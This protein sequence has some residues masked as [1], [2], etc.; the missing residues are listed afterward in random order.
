MN[1]TNLCDTYFAMLEIPSLREMDIVACQIRHR[2]ASF[3]PAI[4]ARSAGIDFSSDDD[5]Y[6]HWLD[7]GRQLGLEWA[8]GKDTLLKIILKAKNEA[9]LIDAWVE[10]HAAIVGYENLIILDCGSDDPQYLR[11]LWAIGQRVL[12]LPFRYYYDHL[13]WIFANP[14][15]FKLISQNCR[16]LTIL[17]ADEFL[18]GRSGQFFSGSLVKPVLR[19][20][21]LPFHCGTW[22]EARGGAALEGMKTVPDWAFDVSIGALVLGTHAGKAVARSD[23]IFEINYLSHNFHVASAAKFATADSLGQ[24]MV[25]HVKNLPPAAMQE[26][27]LRH[28]A[29]KGL[30]THQLRGKP[31]AQIAALLD[32][33][34]IEAHAKLYARDFL[35]L[36]TAVWPVVDEG[37]VAADLIGDRPPQLVPALAAALDAADLPAEFEGWRKNL[38]LDGGS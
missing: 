15:F 27:I 6:Q 10:H 5:A 16:Y 29:A 32:M 25:L 9:Y 3:S 38:E 23:L 1:G 28:L 20:N 19:R 34:D 21:D 12:V 30:V 31:L 24:L 14:D 7:I 26:R 35:D 2:T 37:L 33:P 4:Y 22:V 17:D 8:P 11:K 18:V 13:P 36:E